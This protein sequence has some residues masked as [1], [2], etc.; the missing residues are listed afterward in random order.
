MTLTF[1]KVKS[2][3][4]Y[5]YFHNHNHQSFV[6]WADKVLLIMTGLPH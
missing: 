2:V 1:G 3:L 6:V 5:L 4:Q